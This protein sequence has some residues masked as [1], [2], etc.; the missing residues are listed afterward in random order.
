MYVCVCVC[1]EGDLEKNKKAQWAEGFLPQ[2]KFVGQTDS[3]FI[4]LESKIKKR[5]QNEDSCILLI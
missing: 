4:K 3:N 5:K 2:T 1:E